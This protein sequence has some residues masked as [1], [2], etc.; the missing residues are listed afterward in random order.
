MD[1]KQHIR[2]VPNFPKPDINF[3]DITTLLANPSAFQYVI[4]Q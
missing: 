4:E 1:L 2:T 3:Y